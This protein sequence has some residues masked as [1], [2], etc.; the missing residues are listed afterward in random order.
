[1]TLHPRVCPPLTPLEPEVLPD[2]SQLPDTTQ[3]AYGQN[4]GSPARYLVLD[5]TSWIENVHKSFVQTGEADS[6]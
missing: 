5:I 4:D 6:R 2:R 1:M 3:Y